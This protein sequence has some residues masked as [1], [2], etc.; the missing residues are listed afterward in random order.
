[1]AQIGTQKF[2]VEVEASVDPAEGYYLGEK[3]ASPAEVTLRGP[4]DELARVAR[5][6]ARVE[7]D[8]KRDRTMLDSAA[9]EFLD[10]DGQP[11]QTAASRCWRVNR[12]R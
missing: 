3:Q 8:E 2:T 12:W 6:V 4:V 7:S 10:A 1:M 11:S 5:V 9:L